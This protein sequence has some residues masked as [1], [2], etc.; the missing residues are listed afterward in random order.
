MNRVL[1]PYD[2]SSNARRALALAM[3]GF[4]FGREVE[5]DLLH[6]VDSD[7]Y[8]NV[9]ASKYVPSDEAIRSYLDDEVKQLQA[10]LEVANAATSVLEL[11]APKTTVA[12]GRAHAC[13]DERM[14]EAGVVGVLIGGQ[15]HGGVRERLLGRTAQRVIRHAEVP[16]LIVKRGRD[17]GVPSRLMSGVDWSV[18][19]RHALSMAARLSSAR[20]AKLEVVHVIDSP[21][22][23]YMKA[24]AHERDANGALD[25]IRAQQLDRLETFVGRALAEI[26]PKPAIAKQ[27]LFGDPAETL[28][29][30]ARTS[31]SELLVV[32]GHGHSDVARYL[33][34]ST[35]E[36]LV[37]S[38]AADILVVT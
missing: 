34:G 30:H 28:A 17:L 23:P 6:V 12:R 37:T 19:S 11:I 20:G 38:T 26:E 36:K 21:Y 22:V 25:E 2:F 8:D 13:I 32:G 4:P 35:A 1:V 16:V 31:L 9:L 10:E 24:F 3:Q 7:L 15:G 29:A 18:H 14:R 33:L 5:I 27:I